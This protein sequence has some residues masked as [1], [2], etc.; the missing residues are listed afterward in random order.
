MNEDSLQATDT[1]IELLDFHPPRKD[2]LADVLRGLQAREK[3][4]SSMYF[5][6]ERGSRLFDEIC[7]L[8]EYYPTRT[9]LSIMDAHIEEMCD[10]LGPHCMLVEFGSGSSLKTR[11][12]LEHLDT[13]AAYVPVEISR[14]H[15]VNSAE[16]L[17]AQFP[18]IEILPVCADFTQDFELPE[19]SQPPLRTVVYFPGST[20]GNFDPE[21]ALD[22]LRRMAGLAGEG[23]G[24][25]I[26]VDLEKDSAM[27]ERAYND[28]AGVTAQF[29]LNILE[30]LNR[31]L[32]ADFDQDGF[33]H[34][35]IWNASR[36]RI[37]MHL[38]SRRAQRVTLRDHTVSFA[39]GESIHTESSYKF[40]LER[41]ANLAAQGGLTV[42]Q[43]W[44]DE[45]GLFSVQYLSVRTG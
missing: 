5:Y 36:H 39:L 26:G 24:V 20:I 33:A 42:D 13:P 17:H 27:L 22:L 10:A 14:E 15:L 41:F 30:R 44:M 12:L 25:L 3:W 18:G 38:V 9:E 16:Q 1:E 23:G 37:E 32:G 43:V 19:S 6:D 7:E 11:A 29:N 40:T 31:E 28:K 45:R 34:E 2:M 4:L 35:A 21:D 8:P